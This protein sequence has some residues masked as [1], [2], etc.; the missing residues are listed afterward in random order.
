MLDRI[1][2]AVLQDVPEPGDVAVYIGLRVF[3][4]VAH[5]GLGGE[6]NHHVRPPKGLEQ[7]IDGRRVDQVDPRQGELASL[8]VYPGH[9]VGGLSCGS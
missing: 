3:Q 8:A 4:G 6:V 2:T 7:F 1:A 5:A 9:T